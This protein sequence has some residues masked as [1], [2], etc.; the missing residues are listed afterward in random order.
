LLRYAEGGELRQL[1]GCTIL[2]E[3]SEGLAVVKRE[4][5]AS[6][7]DTGGLDEDKST[8]EKEVEVGIFDR[9]LGIAS[10]TAVV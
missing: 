4:R 3:P 9:I 2:D 1:I 5:V 8:C 10:L 7:E 6:V